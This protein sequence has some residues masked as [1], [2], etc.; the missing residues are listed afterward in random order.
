MY[1]FKS[2]DLRTCKDW[3]ERRSAIINTVPVYTAHPLHFVKLIN[4]NTGT[5]KEN[6]WKYMLLTLYVVFPSKKN[7]LKVCITI[8]S[9]QFVKTNFH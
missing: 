3:K 2:D 6:S 8:D 5:W 7:N 4:Q 9:F 1:G